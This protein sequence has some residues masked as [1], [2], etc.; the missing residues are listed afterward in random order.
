MNESPVTP[1]N[2]PNLWARALFMILMALAYHVTGTVIFIVTIIQFV[3][4]LL[5]DKPNDRLVSLGRSLGN[6]LRQIVNFLTF[7][8][9]EK[10]FPFSDWPSGD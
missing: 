4:M 2:Q 10:P 3:M 5:T 8:T 9:E 1:I 7:V 6:Y